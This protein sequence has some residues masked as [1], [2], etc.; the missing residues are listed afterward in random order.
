MLDLRKYGVGYYH[1]AGS[2]TLCST[3]MFQ[4]RA[5][6]WKIQRDIGRNMKRPD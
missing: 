3:T 4:I 6:G 2:V 5:D 1:Y